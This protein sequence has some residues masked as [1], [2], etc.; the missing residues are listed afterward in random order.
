MDAARSFFN[1]VSR[2]ISG[3]INYEHT[4]FILVSFLFMLGSF[5]WYCHVFSDPV[6][7]E[8]SCNSY[9][10]LALWLNFLG[11]LLAIYVMG[12]QM[13]YGNSDGFGGFGSGSGGFG[14][15]GFGSDGSSNIDR[16][17]SKRF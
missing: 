8:G 12:K 15:G 16:L 14:S 5:F 9:K 11:V 2:A 6:D 4:G 1:M 3:F 17:M 10:G 13:L 7:T